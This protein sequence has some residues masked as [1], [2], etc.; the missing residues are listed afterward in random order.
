MASNSGIN[1]RSPSAARP[2]AGS[3]STSKRW[4]PASTSRRTSPAPRAEVVLLSRS[5]CSAPARRAL[6]STAAR[7]CGMGANVAGAETSLNGTI[8]PG[9]RCRNT[10]TAAVTG[11]CD[12]TAI[13]SSSARG[14]RSS[15]TSALRRDLREPQ[16]VI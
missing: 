12:S 1:A 15:I 14:E 7:R 2:S 3:T 6:A 9:S 16:R 13:T 5:T 8:G 4:Q 10:S 11:C